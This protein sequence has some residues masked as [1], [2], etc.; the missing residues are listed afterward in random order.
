MVL[1]LEAV[2][3]PLTQVLLVVITGLIRQKLSL[4]LS[5]PILDLTQLNQF[6]GFRKNGVCRLQIDYRETDV[7]AS[8]I[9]SF[10]QVVMCRGRQQ[11]RGFWIR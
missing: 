4:I 8:I 3:T 5:R 6:F 2:F 10:F 7:P 11:K 1:T 9:R